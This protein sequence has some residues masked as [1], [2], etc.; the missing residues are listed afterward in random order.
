MSFNMTGNLDMATISKGPSP[1]NDLRQLV[2]K[3]VLAHEFES[4]FQ[5]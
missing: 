2:L 3:C 5:K 1:F 4:S